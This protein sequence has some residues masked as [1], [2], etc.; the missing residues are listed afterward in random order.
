MREIYLITLSGQD[1][2][3]VTASLTETLARY[4][5]TILDVGQAVIHEL[6]TLGMLIEVPAEAQSGPILKDLLFK[7][8]E[9][10][11]RIRLSSRF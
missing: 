7:A 9:L 6:L 4:G 10:D 5:A 2:P 1:R 3:G 8:H 11:L